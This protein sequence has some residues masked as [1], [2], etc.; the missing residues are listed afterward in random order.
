MILHGNNLII[1]VGGTAIAASKSCRI[2]IT[3]DRQEI[4]NATDGKWR[5]FKWGRQSWKVQTSHLVTTIARS[6]SMVGTTVSLEVG[7]QGGLPFS[8]FVDDVSVQSGTYSGTPSA[9]VWDK[10][11]KVFLGVVYASGTTKY[12]DDWTG[13]NPDA[14]IDPS[15]YDPFTDRNGVTYT[16]LEGDLTAEKLTGSA[17]VLSWDCQG[18]VA[19]L[20]SGE[21]EFG[22]N[23]PLTPAT[24]S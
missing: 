13:G 22:G 4:T 15:P 12:Y 21:F 10:T 23:G 7:L 3:A 18:S 5:R 6:A 17:D 8:L 19:H 2:S 20:A 11:A 24:I 9:I 1:K 16:W 14:Y